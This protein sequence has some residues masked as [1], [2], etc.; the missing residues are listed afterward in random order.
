MSKKWYAL[1]IETVEK[2]LETDAANG[3]S[4]KAARSRLKNAGG[5]SFFFVA[6][7][8]IRSCLKAVLADPLLLLLIG[9]D[10]V[11]IIFGERI[12]AV[13]SAILLALNLTAV[14][15]G[16]IK[17]QRIIESMSGFSQPKV[18]VIRDGNLYLVDSRC[19]VPGDVML[20]GVG[21]ILPADARIISSDNLKVRVY[22]GN[23]DDEEYKNVIP[24]ASYICGENDNGEFFEHVNMLYAGTVIQSG[25][26]R[27]MVVET[28]EKT[29]IGAL[30]GGVP[31]NDHTARPELLNQMKRFS[32]TYSFIVLLMIL[33]LTVV[34]I[35]T[36]GAN[37]IL[38]TFIMTLSL[39]VSSLG[40]TVY[41]VG[42]IITA[43]S[44]YRT[45][46]EKGKNNCA[47]IKSIGKVGKLAATDRLV[48]VGNAA[49]TDGVLRINRIYTDGKELN[50]NDL[51]SPSALRIAELAFIIN[52][53]SAAFPSNGENITVL[54][55]S[56]GSYCRLIGVDEERLNISVTPVL[57]AYG[58]RMTAVYRDGDRQMTVCADRFGYIADLCVNEYI[59]GELV[60]ISNERRT[61]IKKAF[62]DL[63]EKGNTAFIITTHIGKTV[64][65]EGI[66]SFG[67]EL[68][69][70]CA[71]VIYDMNRS[72]VKTVLILRDETNANISA[73]I[74]AGIVN[75]KS[76]ILFASKFKRE[77]KG[78]QDIPDDC[79]AF[80]GF[81]S[82]EQRNIIDSI[83]DKGHTVT[84]FASET[85]ASVGRVNV[86]SAAD[87]TITCDRAEYIIGSDSSDVMEYRTPSGVGESLDGAQVLRVSSDVLV[88]RANGESGG[89]I[90]IF[91]AV[92]FAR[93]LQ[94][95]L[96]KAVSYLLCS[97]VA[98]L[99]FVLPSVL[100][101][102][103]ALTPFQL[104]F[105]GLIFDLGALFVIA[106][107][108]TDEYEMSK[109]FKHISLRKPWL[110]CKDLLIA[111]SVSVGIGSLVSV[112]I[113]F[114]A[115]VNISGAVFVSLL[116]V[117]L[118][119]LSRLRY[120]GSIKAEFTK[121][122]I[123]LLSVTF[124]IVLLLSVIPF[125]AAV[126]GVLFSLLSLIA[127]PLAPLGVG[128]YDLI[129]RLISKLK[130]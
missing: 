29:Y 74:N 15:F 113:G 11:A 104:L 5:N 102:I 65:Y 112:L 26:V 120:N 60:L 63:S 54:P 108:Q 57:F 45:A 123:I 107:D 16:Y 101:G 128:L 20:L 3:L 59:G 53:V 34:G 47:M 39:A 30:Q 4:R 81:N 114:I 97:Q 50:K 17:A 35:F 115:K 23:S 86:F 13:S 71:D 105:S 66:I 127:L 103:Y 121:P 62:A 1:D 85:L 95:K 10:I 51:L 7:K 124:G 37:N 130:K 75:S 98:R 78:I 31:L 118:L 28:G 119:I 129:G 46:T 12:T 18:R 110:I 109:P 72:G 52:K 99:I 42:H 61:M 82:R 40:Q 80:M 125:T 70:H 88:K 49:I 32:G 106:M 22:L 76:E 67:T 55:D 126:S 48:L 77:G 27:A 33:P 25:S 58:N 96:K 24:D 92:A 89:I 44:L 90:G 93:S 64:T 9:V 6:T 91:N 94:S 69:Q 41:A 21:D 8:S 14:I 56:I 38:S 87:V 2:E 83:V 43:M 68:I 73:A 122:F 79:K 36:Y 100:F 84:V 111:V 19:I 117:Q 116:A